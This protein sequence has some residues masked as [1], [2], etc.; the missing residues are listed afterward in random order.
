[1]SK[2]GNSL[3]H[4]FDL[5]ILHYDFNSHFMLYFL[6]GKNIKEKWAQEI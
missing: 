6:K 5:S 1:M 2:F 4:I 3:A